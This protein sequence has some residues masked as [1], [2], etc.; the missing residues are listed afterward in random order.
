MVHPVARGG[1]SVNCHQFFSL[2]Y[3]R[4]IV[5]HLD[6]PRGYVKEEIIAAN[7]AIRAQTR[8]QRLTRTNHG[9]DPLQGPGA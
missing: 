1:K 4:A 2:P 5:L 3:N 8:E 7:N 9:L 6:H